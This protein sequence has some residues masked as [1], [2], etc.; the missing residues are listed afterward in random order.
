MTQSRISS[1]LPLVALLTVQ[2]I[3]G[4]NF[5]A[6]KVVLQ[7]Y[8]PTL[9]GAIRLMFSALLMF[10]LSPKLVP[11]GKRRLDPEFLKK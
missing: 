11:A 10:A 5:A 1:A 2:L 9:W 4:F 8:P 3:F 7:H 6:S